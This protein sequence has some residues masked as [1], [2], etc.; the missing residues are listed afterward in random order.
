MGVFRVLYAV[1]V[2]VTESF[3]GCFLTDFVFQ[4]FD[5]DELCSWDCLHRVYGIRLCPSQAKRGCFDN[6]TC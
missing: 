1:Y 2:L 3:L 5:R 6:T 4:C